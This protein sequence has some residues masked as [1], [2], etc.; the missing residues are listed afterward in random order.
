MKISGLSIPF[1]SPGKRIGM[2]MALGSMLLFLLCVNSG[3]ALQV[4]DW[5]IVA[6][7]ESVGLTVRKTPG[8]TSTGVSEMDGTIGHIVSHSNQPTI[9]PLGS[10]SVQYTW[11]Y[12]K[13]ADGH[14]TEGWSAERFPGG[15]VFLERDS[16]AITVNSS[17]KT[18]L[19]FSITGPKDPLT[20]NAYSYSGKTP[21][22]TSGI[23]GDYTVTWSS[24]VS[25]YTTP[26]QQTLSLPANGQITFPGIYQPRKSSA[27]E[28]ENY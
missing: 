3:F 10:G 6:N 17:P 27:K 5:V 26:K 2:R 13:W 14:S 12:I 28:W 7:S 9:A 24:K 22:T 1:S 23:K 20:G 15:R 16:G 19:S 21:F 25:G 8:G 18:D 11:W 4:G